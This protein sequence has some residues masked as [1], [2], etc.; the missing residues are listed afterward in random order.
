MQRKSRFHKRIP[1]LRSVSLM[2]VFIFTYTVCPS[3]I[4]GPKKQPSKGDPSEKTYPVHYVSSP[5][6]HVDGKLTEKAWKRAKQLSDVKL[7]WSEVEPPQTHF[8]AFYGPG[9]FYFSFRVKDD[10]IVVQETVQHEK[11][12]IH[13]DRVELFF[14]RSPSLK[15]YYGLEMD[16]DGLAFTYR[17]S[18]Y[19]NSDLTWNLPEMKLEGTTR[20]D[21]Y[22]VEGRIPL[23]FFLR[24]RLFSGSDANRVMTG[25]FRAEFSRNED[26]DTRHAWMSWIDPGTQG[27]DFHRPQ[28]FGWFVFE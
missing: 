27:A 20:S 8:R 9:G 3:L 2:M 13:E 17:A 26:G 24:H 25:L 10:D 14:A 7:P 5:E 12:I 28:A 21:G 16:P 18:Y 6:I 22:S 1:A 19:R 15:T 23:S 11:D 4:A